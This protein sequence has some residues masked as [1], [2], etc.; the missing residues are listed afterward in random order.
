MPIVVS[1]FV[2]SVMFMQIIVLD[3]AQVSCGHLLLL[4]YALIE[5]ATQTII[6]L[7]LLE[8]QMSKR[9]SFRRVM[10]LHVLLLMI[11]WH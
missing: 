3:S 7:A 9:A 10:G 5:D 8:K 11:F 1:Q 2:L 4:F 6:T